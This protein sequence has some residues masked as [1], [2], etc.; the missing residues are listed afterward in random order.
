M[1][2]DLMVGR[3]EALAV[4]EDGPPSRRPP[5]DVDPWKFL[6]VDDDEEVHKATRFALKN[7]TIDDRPIRLLH[8]YSAREGEQILRREANIACVL[9]D[10]VMETPE[11]GLDLVARIR[12]PLGNRLVRIILRTGQPGQAPELDVVQRYDVNDYKHKAELTNIRLQTTL[13][14]ACRSYQQLQAIEAHRRG[15]AMIVDATRNLMQ[16]TG[17]QRLANGIL[18]QICSLLDVPTEGAVCLGRG[19]DGGKPLRVVA[20]AGRFESLAGRSVD[21]ISDPSMRQFLLARFDER[22]AGRWLD[23]ASLHA[24]LPSGDEVVAHVEHARPLTDLELRLLEVF[25]ANITVAL[26]NADLFEQVHN[27]AFRDRLTGLPNRLSFDQEIARR[28]AALQPFMV[29]VADMDHFHAVNSGLGH[30]FGD[31]ILVEAS[32]VLGATARDMGGYA[33]RL[34]SDAFG[35]ILPAA[36]TTTGEALLAGIHTAIHGPLK[37]GGHRIFSSVSLGAALHPH[38]GD[39]EQLLFRRADMALRKAK[40]EGRGG[41]AF[42]A[43][44]M[45]ESQRERLAMVSQLSEAFT[46]GLLRLYFQPQVRLDNGHT[47]GG[48]A[49]LRWPTGDGRF[50]SPGRFVAAAEDSGLIHDIGDWVLEETC[51]W[52]ARWSDDNR[53]KP[54]LAFNVS[55]VQFRH[56]GF[57]ERLVETINKAGIDPSLLELEITESSLFHDSELIA[58]QLRGFRSIGLRVAVDDFGTGYSSLS[59]LKML[60]IDTL[61]I[62]RSFVVDMTE[63]S[64]NQSIAE[65]VVRI[66]HLLGKEVI[67][68]GVETAAQAASLRAIGCQLGQGFLFSP[69]VPPETFAE[70]LA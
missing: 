38:D 4:K 48:E 40:T 41:T 69:A 64:E 3:D 29:A 70:M 23:Q 50:I 55:P 34:Y 37:V 63:S 26:R 12:G 30:S 28:I 51:R 22:A 1:G 16:E 32:R 62:D 65:A 53:G 59:R 68:E 61:K 60:P 9:L 43:K 57:A 7:V 31:K 8:A 67:A 13:T 58:A 20:A 66:G 17:L 18:T 6:V 47:I 24:V 2:E 44:G 46:A 21:E 35:L 33:A 54:R 25:S 39:T 11:A 15:L 10:V 27:L 19:G 14:T 42:Y 45:G 52:L 5:P 56:P 36:D 49:L